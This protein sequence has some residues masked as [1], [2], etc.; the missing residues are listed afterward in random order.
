MHGATPA[1]ALLP[2]A[3][4]AMAL[5]PGATPVQRG[6]MAVAAL[7]QDVMPLAALRL[8]VAVPLACDVMVARRCYYC[9]RHDGLQRRREACPSVLP[10]CRCAVTVRLQLLAV[11]VAPAAC[12]SHLPAPP[13]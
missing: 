5:R 9:M 2:G 3:T 13:P 1:M 8:A 11:A 6:A 10:S 4:P 7:L 12:W